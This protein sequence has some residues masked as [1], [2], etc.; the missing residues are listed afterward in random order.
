MRQGPHGEAEHVKQRGDDGGQ[1]RH[2]FRRGHTHSQHLVQV[3]HTGHKRA[4]CHNGDGAG[5]GGGRVG[6]AGKR[7]QQR[8]HHV[9]MHRGGGGGQEG[10][11]TPR[12]HAGLRPTDTQR[13]HAHEQAHAH[14][15]DGMW[16]ETTRTASGKRCTSNSVTKPRRQVT[17]TTRRHKPFATHTRTATYNLSALFPAQRQ[18]LKQLRAHRAKLHTAHSQ[19]PEG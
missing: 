19:R 17:D 2:S 14:K 7:G 12:A 18:Q 4:L 13:T 16:W 1:C 9:F 15:N 10:G 11:H 8:G 3:L 6:V 5:G